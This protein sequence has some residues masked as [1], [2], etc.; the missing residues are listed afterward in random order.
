MEIQKEIMEE[1]NKETTKI[2]EVLVSEKKLTN[3]SRKMENVNLLEK[4][5]LLHNPRSTT[6]KAST[7][8]VTPPMRFFLLWNLQ[9]LG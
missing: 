2:K 4:N 8:I 3:V 6:L 7:L 1:V 9:S 5:S